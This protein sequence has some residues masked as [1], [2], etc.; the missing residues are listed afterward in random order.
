MVVYSVLSILGSCQVFENFFFENFFLLWV[1]DRGGQGPGKGPNTS[2]VMKV[3][4]GGLA[5]SRENAITRE[6]LNIFT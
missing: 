2:T 5:P 1:F 6:R 3:Y 4:I